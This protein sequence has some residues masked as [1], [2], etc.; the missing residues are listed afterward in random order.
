MGIAAVLDM[1]NT[2][3]TQQIKF[4]PSR[5]ALHFTNGSN[6]CQNCKISVLS[7]NFVLTWWKIPGSTAGQKRLPLCVKCKISLL[8]RNFLLCERGA[9]KSLRRTHP[10]W[11]C[12]YVCYAYEKSIKNNFLTSQNKKTN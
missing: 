1:N 5:K 7:K 12:F 8:Y 11:Q 6:F 4:L 3:H 2:P 9:G 10:H